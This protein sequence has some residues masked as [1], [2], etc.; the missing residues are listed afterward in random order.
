MK[1]LKKRK[2]TNVV[3]IKDKFIG[4]N[5]SI[6]I[7]SMCNIPT[8]NYKKVYTQIKKLE[9][10][11]CEIIRV[12]VKNDEDV[13]SL[14]K[15]T[16]KINIPIVADIHFDY[17]LALKS[18][19]AGVNKLRINPGNI[20]EKWK[21][22]EIIK[23]AKDSNIPIRVGVN[24]GS[25]EKKLVKLLEEKKITAEDAVVESAIKEVQYLEELDFFNI[26]VSLKTSD[27]FT[28][29][30]C[31]DLFSKKRKYPLHVGITETGTLRTGLIKSGIGIGQILM[32]GIGDTIRVSLSTNPLEE[33]Y[34]A[35]NIL[36]T[37][38]LRDNIPDLIA[39]PTCGRTQI[40]LISL[41]NKVEKILY[42]IKKN[43]KIAVMGCVVNGPG[44]AREADIGITGGNGVG[45]IFKKGK[46]LK[47]V[48][49]TDLL[50]EFQKELEKIR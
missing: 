26:V 42:G 40:K 24:L 44:E 34:A 39:C 3:K 4:G 10:A 15:L 38:K 18:I 37:L 11:G 50:K 36:G 48:K 32:N 29:I 19:E 20:T 31:Y 45:L 41:A 33:I 25:L 12:S 8:E 43:I 47:K 35:Y 6:L 14:K 1:L 30:K 27:V 22:K 17:K 16:K 7:Q 23:S 9:K 49:E 2:K 5:N 13:E 46:I 28:T 21:V